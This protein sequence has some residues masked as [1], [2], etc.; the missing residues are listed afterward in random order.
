MTPSSSTARPT[1]RTTPTTTEAWPAGRLRYEIS[2]IANATPE[3]S[4]MHP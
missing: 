3:I 1:G 4:S 2:G